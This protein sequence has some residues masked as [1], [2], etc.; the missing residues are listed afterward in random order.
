[1]NDLIR[2]FKLENKFKIIKVIKIKFYSIYKK[3]ESHYNIF[4]SK[5]ILTIKTKLKKKVKCGS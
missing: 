2:M 5:S 3:L 1:M 4:F